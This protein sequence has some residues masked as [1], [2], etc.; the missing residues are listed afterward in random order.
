MSVENEAIARRFFE[1][2]CNQR[3]GAVADEIVSADYVS[4][5][6]QAPPAEGPG[7][8]PRPDRRLPGRARRLLGRTGDPLSRS[9]SCRRALD[10]PRYAHGE[11]MGVPATGAPIAVEAITIFGSL[12]AGSPKNG[13]S[14]T[15]SACCNRSARPLSPP[16]R[17]GRSIPSSRAIERPHARKSLSASCFDVGGGVEHLERPAATVPPVR[18]HRR[19]D[20]DR[21]DGVGDQPS[22]GRLTASRVRAAGRCRQDRWQRSRPDR[23]VGPGRCARH[24]D[25][26]SRVRSPRPRRGSAACATRVHEVGRGRVPPDN[27]RPTP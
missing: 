13:Q 15:P 26:R 4:H 20:R 27:A 21:L 8:G 17:E 14:G 6:P 24:R 5:G 11:L 12:T 10:R 23:R 16:R 1:E 7:R 2:L 25:P 22:P 19:R 3:N 9:G 18:C